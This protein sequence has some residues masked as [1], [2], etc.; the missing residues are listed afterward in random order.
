MTDTEV[1]V[2]GWE[3]PET[4]I[5]EVGDDDSDLFKDIY[6]ETSSGMIFEV[7]MFDT[8]CLV[9]PASPNQ[10]AGIRKLNLVEFSGEFHEYGGDPEAVRN[11]LRNANA[12][13]IVE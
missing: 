13:F 4:D 11:Y 7:Q 10:Y 9:R 2:E 6:V 8:F 3:D 1:M 12:D 5:D